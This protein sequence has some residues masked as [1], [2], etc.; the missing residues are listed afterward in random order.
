MLFQYVNKCIQKL[1]ELSSDLHDIQYT[2]V[3]AR[4]GR[5]MS[6]VYKEIARTTCS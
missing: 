2:L 4:H 3:S 6:T 1:Y 5:L